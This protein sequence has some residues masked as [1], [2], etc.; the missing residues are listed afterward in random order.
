MSTD[1][2][3][4]LNNIIDTTEKFALSQ[5]KPDDLTSQRLKNDAKSI[6][7]INPSLAAMVAPVQKRPLPT[8][9]RPS[10]GSA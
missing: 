10:I 4:V 6:L 9:Q 2:S 1:F 5:T 7:K 8:S 3:S